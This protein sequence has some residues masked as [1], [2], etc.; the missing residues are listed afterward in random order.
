MSSYNYLDKTGLGLL[1]S[2]IKDYA[3]PEIMLVTITG[4]VTDGYVADKTYAELRETNIA[5]KQIFLKYS[6][7][8]FYQ[9]G[10]P[11][12]STST[13]PFTFGTL[14]G[15]NE[16]YFS[17]SSADVVSRPELKAVRSVNGKT[18]AVTLGIL[19]LN[20]ATI[21][22]PTDG[23]VLTYDSTAGKWVNADGGGAYYV[24][25]TTTTENGV[26]TYSAD[27]TFDEVY[28]AYQNGNSVYAIN[29]SSIYYLGIA[30]ANGIGFERNSST[31]LQSF[32][33]TKSSN[34]ITYSVSSLSN[35]QTK[36]TFDSA[37][38]SDSTNPVTS[39]G[40][41]TALQNAGKTYT[42]SATN[43][44]IT[45]TG[46]DSS[47]STATF[48]IYDGTILSTWEGGNF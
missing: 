37:P 9:W 13:M 46:S 18:G 30:N 47:T 42:I 44:T 16:Y 34:K 28:E 27:K 31:N 14:V 20:D 29:G 21:T 3:A 26:T 5:G 48:P 40:V 17:I 45:L 32:S 43:N 24:I 39:G 36:L 10:G 7:Y 1:W 15:G 41:F 19:D 8:T 22:S 25:I 12:T 33:W 2:K 6:S 4:N 35:Y 23:Q 38:T 11:K